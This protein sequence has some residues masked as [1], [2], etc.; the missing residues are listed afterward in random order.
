MKYLLTYAYEGIREGKPISGQGSTVMAVIGIDKITPEIITDAVE[1]VRN[2]FIKGGTRIN[3][4]APMGWFKY[5]EE[6][7]EDDK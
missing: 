6:D 3:N 1:W 7:L 2:D 4:I 5:D